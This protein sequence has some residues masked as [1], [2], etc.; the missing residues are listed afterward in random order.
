MSGVNVLF[1]AKETESSILSLKYLLEKRVTVVF[2]VVRPQ[3][4]VL[5]NICHAAKISTGSESDFLA[6]AESLAP[7]DYLF[8]YYWKLVKAETLKLN[9][10][11]RSLRRTILRCTSDI[12]P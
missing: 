3:D 2:A 9:G 8:S 7:V 1:M 4:N 5:Q 11:L 12:K 10:T 6:N